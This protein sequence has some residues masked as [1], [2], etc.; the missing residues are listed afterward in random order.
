MAQQKGAGD[1]A[2]DY[3]NKPV[4]W[5]IDGGAGGLSDTIARTVGQKL[6]E[7]WGHSI[8]ND[9][10][11][12]ASG[13]IAY[14][15]GSKAPADGYTLVFVSAPFAINISVYNK[16]PYDTRRDFAPIGLIATYSLV[17][18][19]NLKVPA[20]TVSEL[21]SYAKGKRGG[22]TWATTG[23]GTSPF[24]ATE[25]FRKEAGFDGVAVTYNS[26]PASLIDLIGGRVE[27]TLVVMPS[28]IT[29]IRA[30]RIHAVGVAS[31]ARSTLLPD[32]PTIAESGLP[33]FQSVGYTGAVAPAKVPR[34]IIE[35]LDNEMVRVL[36]MPD[37]QGRIQ[38]LGAEP[39]WSTPEEFH[40][41]L[42]EEI[43]RWAPVARQAG[44]KLER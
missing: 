8:V 3:P 18:V 14:E 33:G 22:I 28:A 5:I 42:E 11:S 24:L 39:R 32:V 10:R 13:T 36:K 31:P 27:F 30:G 17:L 1:P 20:K 29:H 34:A 37:V 6:T 19:T 40:K 41:I 21:I 44:V 7:A 4:R 16:L 35:K 2:K 15:L 9:N 38:N 43:A 25:L 26:S 12:G 23:P